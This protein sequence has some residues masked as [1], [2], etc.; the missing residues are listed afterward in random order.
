LLRALARAGAEHVVV[1][2]HALAVHGIPR[3]TGD[4]DV[5]VRPSPDNAQRVVEALHEFG[6]PIAEHGVAASDFTAPDVVYQLGLPPRRIDLMTSLTGLTFDEAL[7]DRVEVELG[8]L[9]VPFLGRES[10]LRNKRAT[11][12][13]K[14]LVDVR[15]LTQD[16]GER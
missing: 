3:A 9:L 11:G 2:A 6:A 7:A 13:D 1:G 10:L 8:G 15:L 14:D 16:A 5:L 4:L 12:R